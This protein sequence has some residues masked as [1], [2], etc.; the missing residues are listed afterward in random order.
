MSLQKF[1]FENEEE[2]KEN[3]VKQ[4]RAHRLDGMVES[5]W[6]VYFAQFDLCF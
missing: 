5:V 3:I 2:K 6:L 4:L 1:Q